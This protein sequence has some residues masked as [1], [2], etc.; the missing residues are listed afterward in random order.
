MLVAHE[1]ALAKLSQSLLKPTL[2]GQY[3]ARQD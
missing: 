3:L 1:H 2:L